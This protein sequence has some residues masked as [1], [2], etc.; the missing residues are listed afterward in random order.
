ML[1]E[2]AN[3]S[4]ARRGLRGTKRQQLV[5]PFWLSLMPKRAIGRA[6]RARLALLD[7]AEA[8]VEHT[9]NAMGS[10]DPPVARQLLLAASE[11]LLPNSPHSF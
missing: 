2:T 6:A 3:A 10:R 8:A 11:P 1:A 9:M 5:R 7:E 4:Q